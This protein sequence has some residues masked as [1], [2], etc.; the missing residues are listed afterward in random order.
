[1]KIEI[2]N[3]NK[4]QQS[5]TIKLALLAILGLF[6]LIP[7]EMIKQIILER[8]S[9]GEK[10]KKEISEQWASKQCFA[11][12]VINIP[13]RTI[14][15]E[16][17]EKA[18]TGIW[19]ILPEN[20]NITGIIKPE[21]RYRGIYQSVVYDSE[22]KIKGYFIIP[23]ENVLKNY[24][25]L[26]NEAY[27]TVGIS[28][29]RGLKGKIILKTDS[30]ELEAEPGVRDNDI[31]QSGISFISPVLIPGNKVSLDMSINLSGSEGLLL[32]PIGKS[33]SAHLQS[34]WTSPSFN[35]SFL[36]VKRSVDETGFTADWEVTHLNRN[37]PQNWI[38]SAFHPLESSFGLD[39]FQPVDHYQK[40]WRSSRYG[41]LFIALS[42][43]VLIFLEITRKEIIHI[44]HYFL[45]SLGLVLFFSLLNSLSE[46]V[47]FNVAY[48]ISSIA[49]I[50]MISVFTGTLFR[51][52][53]T[54]WIVFGMLVIL[55]SFIFV[56][57]TLKDYAYLAGNIGLFLLLA[58]VMKLAS[59]LELFKK[60]ALSET[61]EKK[62]N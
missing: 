54:A 25:V 43:L 7:L 35:G 37:F 56:L 15:A 31:F 51:E 52:K 47:G 33:T 6:F 29:N 2:T 36:P 26:W 59:N 12:P 8:Q 28:D 13:V 61:A 27:Y 40:S 21:I 24:E 41:I 50:L 45:V 20:L 19:H 22:L 30:T 60:A 34:E 39:L 58:I 4:W 5:L 32:T 55:Y 44:F 18:I 1:M 3:Q 57:L 11:G 23:E 62:D 48:L 16:K 46:Q 17:D 42:F 49:T 14:P 38:G 9:N 53:K 10:V